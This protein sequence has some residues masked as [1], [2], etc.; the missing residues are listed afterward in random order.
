MALLGTF[1]TTTKTPMGPQR[2]KITF[3]ADGGFSEAKAAEGKSELQDLEVNGDEFSFW[4]QT[5]TPMGDIKV[6]M[7]GKIEGDSL[8]AVADTPF[9][10]A[11][12]TG[13][14]VE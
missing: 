6:S 5:K 3:T 12:V 14:R 2:G 11:N 1:E 9:G 4:I 7:K 13:K 8:T 10:A